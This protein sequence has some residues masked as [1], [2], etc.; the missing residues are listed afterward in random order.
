MEIFNRRGVF[1]YTSGNDERRIAK[2]LHIKADSAEE[3]G[4]H[5][6]ATALRE[7]AKQYERDA[8]RESKRSPFD[9]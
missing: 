4:Y 1:T 6:L 9:E 7:L 5:R 8:E 2:D 3:K